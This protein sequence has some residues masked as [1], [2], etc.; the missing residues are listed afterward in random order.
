MTFRYN[1]PPSEQYPSLRAEYFASQARRHMN[2]AE[3]AAINETRQ[4]A[5]ARAELALGHMQ[6]EAKIVQVAEAAGLGF[7]SDPSEADT[8][9]APAD[10]DWEPETFN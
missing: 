3:T 10:L 4:I 5:T 1:N 2:T 9:P 6:R 7:D 8:I